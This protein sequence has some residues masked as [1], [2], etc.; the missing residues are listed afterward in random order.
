MH[1]YKWPINCT[2]TRTAG[3]T[4]AHSDNGGGEPHGERAAMVSCGL[5][6]DVF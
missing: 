4:D 5:R 1:G 3:G 6:G 2:R